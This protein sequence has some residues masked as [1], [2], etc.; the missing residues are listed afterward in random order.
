MS[1]ELGKGEPQQ[2]QADL[3]ESLQRLLHLLVAYL[4]SCDPAECAASRQGDVQNACWGVLES[5][6]LPALPAPH[7][8][9]RGI[10]EL[11]CPA[12]AAQ[13]ELLHHCVAVAVHGLRNHQLHMPLHCLQEWKCVFQATPVLSCPL[14]VAG[15]EWHGVWTIQV[16]S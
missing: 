9:N 5:A 3:H 11:P 1:C 8:S 2:W 7:V 14:Q 12:L 6:G 15:D 10:V 4:G 13:T 16:H